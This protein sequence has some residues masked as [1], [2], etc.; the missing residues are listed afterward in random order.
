M[1]G[2]FSSGKNKDIKNSVVEINIDKVRP[3]P[4]QPRKVF[5]TA[6]IYELAESIKEFGVIQPISVRKA[7]KGA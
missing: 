4:Y 1:E 3:N 7:H 6:S 2:F 5:D